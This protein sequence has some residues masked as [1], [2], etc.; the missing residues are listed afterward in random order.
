[1]YYGTS[2]V[3]GEGVGRSGMPHPSQLGRL[4]HQEVI[5]LGFSG[6][7]WCEPAVAEAMGRLNTQLF[8]VDCLPNNNPVEL[9]QR[10]GLFLKIL[11]Q[12]QP[13]TPILL[14]ED[15]ECGGAKFQPAYACQRSD[16]NAVL[17]SVMRTCAPQALATSHSRQPRLVWRRW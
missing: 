11:R 4:L 16:K 13:T 9:Q 7:A 12:A 14:V 3:Q 1:M 2:I 17:H 10:L 8:V 15:R 5:N 6:R